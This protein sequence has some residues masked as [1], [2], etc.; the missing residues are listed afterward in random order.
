L[1]SRTT[2]RIGVSGQL[3]D[4]HS[5]APNTP[6]KPTHITATHVS[7]RV[8]KTASRLPSAMANK[9]RSKREGE[10]RGGGGAEEPEGKAG[11]LGLSN[12]SI[13]MFCLSITFLFHTST[14]PHPLS[15]HRSRPAQHGRDGFKQDLQIEC[16]RPSVDVFK[17]LP[18]PLIEARLAAP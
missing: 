2:C 11:W 13:I 9:R 7:D 8:A 10:R 6:H 4:R 14:L 1:A 17:V 3:A 12:S 15:L 18:D 5:M 16:E